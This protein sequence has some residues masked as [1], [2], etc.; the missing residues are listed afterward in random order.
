[1]TPIQTAA[2]M[3]IRRRMDQMRETENLYKTPN[4]ATIAAILDSTTVDPDGNHI[5]IVKT[6]APASQLTRETLYGIS[7]IDLN[8]CGA[9]PRTADTSEVVVRDDSTVTITWHD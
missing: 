6:A 1:M 7:D 8:Q 5:L 2:S 4:A 3:L 9:T